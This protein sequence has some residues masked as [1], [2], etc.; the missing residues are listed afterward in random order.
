MSRPSKIQLLLED[1][2][3]LIF[4][5][6]YMDSGE[7]LSWLEEYRGSG[8]THISSKGTL[9]RLSTRPG[10]DSLRGRAAKKVKN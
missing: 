2:K 10:V 8:E 6:A 4:C 1:K 3:T 9:P 5:L 7:D